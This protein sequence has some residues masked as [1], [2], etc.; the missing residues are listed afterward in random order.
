MTDEWIVEKAKEGS[1]YEF[2]VNDTLTLTARTGMGKYYK[3]SF[4]ANGDAE[5]TNF[6]VNRLAQYYDI[7]E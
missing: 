2:Y 5:F 7:Y 1:I 6:S 4:Y 3:P